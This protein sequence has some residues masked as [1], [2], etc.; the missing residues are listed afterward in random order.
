MRVLLVTNYFPPHYA[1]GAEVVV[2]NEC[3]GLRQR[4]VEASVLMVNGRMAQGQDE[5][6]QVQDVPVHEISHRPYLF[7]N[8]AVQA[9]DPRV[10]RD[11]AAEIGRVQPDL[12]HIHNV[13]GASLAP[14][15]ACR[16]AGVPAVLTLHDYWLLCPNNMLYRQDGAL[17]DPAATPG[18]CRRCFRR[19]DFWADIPRRR[20]VFARLVGSVRLFISPSQ[21]LVDLHTAAG[22]D[23]ARFRV[24]PNGIKPALF[25]PP[26]NP[27]VREIVHEAGLFRTLLFA[28]AVVET[29]GVQT[30]I[31]AAPLLSRYVDRFRLVVAGEGEQRLMAALRRL[32]RSGVELLGRVP[33]QEMRSLYA[34]ADLTVVPS[35]WY[36]NSSMVVYE[37]LLAGT[38]VLASAIGGT[39]ELIDEEATGYTFPPRDTAA[40]VAR[41]V[42]H[43]SRSAPE[44]RQMRRQCIEQAHSQMT[45]DRH[46]DRLQNVYVEALET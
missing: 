26:S 15:A 21:R 38:P 2:Y 5:H 41:A 9:F 23:P 44:R 42:Q 29:K 20:Q 18:A 7:N 37:S 19:Y 28:G 27:R 22:Y 45:L 31:E 30:L 39:P 12:V 40:L 4:G 24:V 14:F 1:G 25:Q 8:P 46:L 10:Y 34:A 35:T 3:H 16:R 17:C 36:E 13:S 33:F 32:D 6:R 11:V 43:F